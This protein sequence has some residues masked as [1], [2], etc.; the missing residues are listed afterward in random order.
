M[1]HSWIELYWEHP[2]FRFLPCSFHWR[3]H[4]AFRRKIAKLELEPK[5]RPFFLEITAI[6]GK[7]VAKSEIDS[8]WRLFSLAL[9]RGGPRNLNPAPAS[10]SLGTT[11]IRHRWTNLFSENKFVLRK[12]Y[13]VQVS[14]YKRMYP[15]SFR[16][17]AKSLQLT[18]Y[19]ISYLMKINNFKNFTFLLKVFAKQN[20]LQKNELDRKTQ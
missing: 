7:K 15:Y 8:K 1:S 16:V 3:T 19:I 5:W 18:N 13:K 12:K 11:A 9:A 20:W 4:Q 6:L 10:N 2:S 17:D 14:N